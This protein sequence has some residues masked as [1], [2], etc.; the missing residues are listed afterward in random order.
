LILVGGDV[1]LSVLILVADD[2]FLPVLLL[3]L[4]FKVK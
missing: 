3:A 2:D 1:F 4:V